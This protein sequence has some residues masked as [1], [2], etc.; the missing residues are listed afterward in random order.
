MIFRPYYTFET[1]CAG[2]LLGC[3]GLGKCAVVVV[4]PA[5]RVSGC[6]SRAA[7]YSSTPSSTRSRS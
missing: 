7:P 2:Y 5:P 6:M 1:G 4:G 3:G